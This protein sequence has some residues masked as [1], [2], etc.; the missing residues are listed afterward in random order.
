MRAVLYVRIQQLLVLKGIWL[1]FCDIYFKVDPVGPIT[2]T[3]VS[4]K[5]V[6]IQVDKTGDSQNYNH[7]VVRRNVWDE[8]CH[9][10]IHNSVTDD[11]TD[12]DARPTGNHYEIY[13]ANSGGSS[14]PK[15]YS[16]APLSDERTHLIITK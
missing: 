16:P 14:W 1:V 4:T 10:P 15:S 8:I 13:A 9:I 7:F 12:K 5:F 2:F 11:C 6:N 3:A